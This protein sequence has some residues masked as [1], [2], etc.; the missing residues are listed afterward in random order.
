MRTDIEYLVSIRKELRTSES[1]I[2]K[3]IEDI[4]EEIMNECDIELR[5]ELYKRSNDLYYRR[6]AVRGQLHLLSHL[7]NYDSPLNTDGLLVIRE[8]GF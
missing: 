5:K 8:D 6:Q 2:S 3:R 4:R 1:M 7:L